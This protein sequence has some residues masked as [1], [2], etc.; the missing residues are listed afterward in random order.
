MTFFQPTSSS[1]GTWYS[2]EIG[3]I[4]LN[5]ALAN[6]TASYQYPD[7]TITS[8]TPSIGTNPGTSASDTNTDKGVYWV[9][10]DVKNTGTQ[11]R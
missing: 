7:L 8:S 4:N 10:G 11:T 2:V 3:N 1:D 6:A 9:N 5:V